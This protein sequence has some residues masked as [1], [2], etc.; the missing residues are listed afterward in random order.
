MPNA[1]AEMSRIRLAGLPTPL[2]PM[3]RLTAAT[4]GPELWIKRDDCTVLGGG[5]NK[6]RKLEY[7]MADAIDQG[8]DI[9]L[10]AGAKQSNH[11]RQTAAAAAKLG[12][13]CRLLL[14]DSVDGRGEAY[15]QGGN[16]MLSRLFGAEVEF[17]AKGTGL[18][19]ALDAHAEALRAAGRR[20]YVIPAGGSSVVGA[21]AYA[22]AI[23]ELFAQMSDLGVTFDRIVVATGSFGTHAGLLAGLAKMGSSIPVTGVSVGR[24]REVLT[25]LVTALAEETLERI[26]PGVRLAEDAVDVDDGFVGAGYG[27]PTPEMLEAVRLVAQTEGILLDPV[28][29][30]KAMAALLARIA[31]GTF[32]ALSRILFWHTGGSQGL[33]AYDEIFSFANLERT[34]ADPQPA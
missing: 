11:A 32:A 7:L 27:Q 30:G 10:T 16:I 21:A 17:L 1:R 26:A 24:S 13:D 9:V 2:E 18:A 5:G 12:I 19:D 22:D 14:A 29:S 3:P 25:P 34:A 20:P 31:D 6:A 8:A 23:P 4:G 28:Y 15:A 33:F